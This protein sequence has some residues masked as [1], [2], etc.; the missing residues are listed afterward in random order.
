VIAQEDSENCSRETSE[1]R[2]SSTG[3]D[4]QADENPASEN[5]SERSYNTGDITDL[6]D[7]TNETEDNV[8]II[9]I[10]SDLSSSG[11]HDDIDTSRHIT[12]LATTRINKR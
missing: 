10:S 5:D 4:R 12:T 7:E 6:D 9:S 1:E 2:E 11:E 3:Q 8:S